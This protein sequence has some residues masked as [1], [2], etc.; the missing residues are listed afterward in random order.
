M[1]QIPKEILLA[2]LSAILG[3]LFTIIVTYAN[4]RA[5]RFELKY[6]YK[7]KLEENYCLNTQKHLD[8]I[9]LPLYKLLL[10]FKKSW[11]SLKHSEDFAGSVKTFIDKE[12]YKLKGFKE[13]LDDRGLTAFLLPDVEN[14]LD[15]LLAFLLQSLNT[16]DLAYKLFIEYERYKLKN[17]VF[18]R[19]EIPIFSKNQNRNLNTYQ[20]KVASLIY[21]IAFDIINSFK[22]VLPFSL[23]DYEIKVVVASAP[24]NSEEFEVQLLSFI[25][26]INNKIK[27]LTLGIVR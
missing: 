6:N 11:V 26:D 7:V 24:L 9:Y 4:F 19:K 14:S 22:A 25:T 3:G 5:K 8:E 23:V 15:R 21:K 2:S 27:D 17:I 13:D 12:A 16:K 18:Y 1:P 20:K 10:S